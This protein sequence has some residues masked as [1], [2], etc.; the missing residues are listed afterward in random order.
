V[1]GKKTT[2]G[3]IQ[4]TKGWYPEGKT[5]QNVPEIKEY[6]DKVLDQL[7]KYTHTR[8]PEYVELLVENCLAEKQWEDALAYFLRYIRAEG[9]EIGIDNKQQT[10][11][12]KTM[13]K[14]FELRFIRGLIHSVGLGFM[15]EEILGLEVERLYGGNKDLSALK[16]LLNGPPRRKE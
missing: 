9:L 8:S 3:F 15:E 14:L 5:F 13:D 10:K 4:K 2:D 7:S 16:G 12:R 11:I 6:Y 1:S